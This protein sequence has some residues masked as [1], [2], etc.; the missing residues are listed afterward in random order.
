MKDNPNF[1]GG[2]L[3][4]DKPKG[5]TSQSAVN[6]V[7]RAFGTR[8]AGHTGTLDPLASGLLTV[9]VGRAVKASEYA[10]CDRKKYEAVF[11]AGLR[12]DTEDITGTV[13]EERDADIRDDEMDDVTRRFTGTILQVPPMYSAIKIGGKKLYE[14]AREGKTVERTPR[15]VTVYSLTSERI[16]RCEF[17][18]NVECSSGTYIR[19]L[20][21]DIGD[22]LGTGGCMAELRRT[23]VGH[24]GI[25]EAITIEE[26]Q[27]ISENKEELYKRIIPVEELFSGLPLVCLSEFYMHLMKNGCEIY[28][29]K[30]GKNVSELKPGDRVRIVDSNGLFTAVA[31]AK[32]YPNGTALKSLKLFRL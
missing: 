31:E 19:T 8:Q 3:L 22:A 13:L 16:S 18:L 11:R 5:I 24:F 23:A 27:R 10:V 6:E 26:L 7:R 12:T 17:R 20:C 15:P 2:I 25:D 30:L 1:E 29:S 28:L 9:L 4:I 32:E 14:L 21:A